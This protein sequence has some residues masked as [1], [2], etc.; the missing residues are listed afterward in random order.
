MFW[1]RWV[2]AQGERVRFERYSLLPNP[3]CEW[4]GRALVGGAWLVARAGGALGRFQA[5]K[6]LPAQR[7]R[8]VS[9]FSSVRFGSIR[10]L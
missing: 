7:L 5:L 3:M 9:P 10:P 1:G 4:A 8:G 6:R 2:P